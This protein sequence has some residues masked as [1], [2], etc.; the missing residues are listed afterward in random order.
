MKLLFLCSVYLSISS[1]FSLCCIGILSIFPW[2][3]R[4][5]ELIIFTIGSYWFNIALIIKSLMILIN[6]RR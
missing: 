1:V 3:V 5:V 4:M 2:E 6:S